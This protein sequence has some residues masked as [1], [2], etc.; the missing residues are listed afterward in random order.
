MIARV[1]GIVEDRNTKQIH[2]CYFCGGPGTGR[3]D[4]DR[5]ICPKCR[6]LLQTWNIHEKSTRE[7]VEDKRL[8]RMYRKQREHFLHAEYNVKRVQFLQENPFCWVALLV[9][10]KLERSKVV[11]HRCGRVGENFLDEKTWIAT[12]RHG[13]RWIHQNEEKARELGLLA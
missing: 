9:F 6:R 2:F 10:K 5:R 1:M 8:R 7:E 3:F 12:T 13:D 11:H 4:D